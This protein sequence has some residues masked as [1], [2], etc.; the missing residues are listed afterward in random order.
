[1]STEALAIPEITPEQADLVRRT[2][3]KDAT[4]DELQLFFYDCKR[5]G[6]HPLDRLIHFTKRSG[7]YTP[8]TSIDFMR[9]RAADSGQYAGNDDPVFQYADNERLPQAAFVTVYRMCEGQRCAFTATARWTEYF[10]GDAQGW[11]WKKMPHIML[12]KVAEALAL[13]KAF[14]QQLAGLYE[15]A[16][17][18][19]AAKGQK[20]E[21]APQIVAGVLS[22]CKAFDSCSIAKIGKFKV[23]IKDNAHDSFLAQ[24]EG[25]Q[26]EVEVRE[27]IGPKGKYLGLVQILSIEGRPYLETA[28]EASV[29]SLPKKSEVVHAQTAVIASPHADPNVIEAAK[30]A[31]AELDKKKGLNAKGRAKQ[32]RGESLA[33]PLNLDAEDALLIGEKDEFGVIINP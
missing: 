29:H 1:M 11:A 12:G 23:V 10:P 24:C 28:L 25:K 16:E 5:R 26:I 17:M 8:I 30:L 20:E 2:V 27:G 19:Q 3:A 7:K 18:D 31:Q 32:A 13:R 21:S 6:V 15:A 14:P 9:T 22:E 4:A 33:A